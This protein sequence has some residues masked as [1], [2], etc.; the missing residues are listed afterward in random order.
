MGQLWVGN[1]SR[2]V[3]LHRVPKSLFFIASVRFFPRNAEPFRVE[4]A[5]VHFFQKNTF[6]LTS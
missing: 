1:L 5:I 6:P 3:K 2:L 4:T